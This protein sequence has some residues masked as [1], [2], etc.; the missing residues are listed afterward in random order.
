MSTVKVNLFCFSALRNELAIKTFSR[1][2]SGQEYLLVTINCKLTG[3]KS[4]R[5]NSGRR[6]ASTDDHDSDYSLDVDEGSIHVTPWD[7][8]MSKTVT[9][10]RD[11][12]KEHCSL[13]TNE[14]KV[15]YYNCLSPLNH[16]VRKDF[17]EDPVWYIFSSRQCFSKICS[18][19]GEAV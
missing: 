7:R 18:V 9:Y 6:K 14:Q 10:K 17:Y 1:L 5:A 2:P 15:H 19:S 3:K 8:R 4:E 11:S 16:L 13:L 12:K